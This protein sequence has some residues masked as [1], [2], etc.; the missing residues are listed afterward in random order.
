M[1]APTAPLRASTSVRTHCC[2]SRHIHRSYRGA[3]ARLRRAQHSCGGPK[4]TPTLL[5]APE[6]SGQHRN[7]SS[8]RSTPAQ[9][10]ARR[11]P[12]A[13][14]CAHAH[15]HITDRDRRDTC[16]TPSTRHAFHVDA[17]ATRRT[18]RS[19]PQTRAIDAARSTPSTPRAPRRSEIAPQRARRRRGARLRWHGVPPQS[20][21]R[22]S[23]VGLT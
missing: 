22:R 21:G 4:R 3:R 13:R 19:T 12:A 14:P 20:K 1:A 15:K 18:M 5:G 2:R 23:G 17:S 16:S 6:S 9:R 11:G 8:A 10:R 7:T